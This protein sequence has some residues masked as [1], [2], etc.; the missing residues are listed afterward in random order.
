MNSMFVRDYAG[1]GQPSHMEEIG[2]LP[3]ANKPGLSEEQ[4]KMLADLMM[5]GGGGDSYIP[6]SGFLGVLAQGANAAS[7][8]YMGK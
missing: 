5:G 1:G 6:D 7:R 8:H 3:G 4:R 2:S